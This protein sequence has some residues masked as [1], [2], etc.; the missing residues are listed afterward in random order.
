[1]A[2][3]VKADKA[4]FV[5]PEL[6]AG[7]SIPRPAVEPVNGRFLSE[8]G[9]DFTD[10]FIK[11]AEETLKICRLHRCKVAILKSG[12]PSCGSGQIPDGNFNGGLVDGDGATAKLLKKNGITVISERELEDIASN[13][14]NDPNLQELF[15][16]IKH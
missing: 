6:L 8:E 11:G 15:Q 12:S 4:I 10:A 9:G 16:L 2:Q 3:L 7:L 5:C 14:T 1:M 13:G